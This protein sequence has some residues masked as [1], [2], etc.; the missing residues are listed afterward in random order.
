M[1]PIVVVLQL[2][3]VT[4]HNVLQMYSLAEQHNAHKLKTALMKFIKKNRN[5]L[6]ASSEHIIFIEEEK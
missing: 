2:R 6:M 5:L 3:T 4:I 1:A